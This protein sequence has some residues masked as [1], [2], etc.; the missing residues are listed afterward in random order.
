MSSLE[1]FPEGDGTR[2]QTDRLRYLADS[3]DC[4]TEEDLILLTRTTP[5]TVMAW[6]KR[7]KGPV[8]ILVGNR[9]LYPRQAVAEFLT[10]ST[11]QRTAPLGK[12]S[13]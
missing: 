2:A 9:F 5:G 1:N 11:R 3:L 10:N 13:L 7:G 12:D 8:Y 4:L 6:R